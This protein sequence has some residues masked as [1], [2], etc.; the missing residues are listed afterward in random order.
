V[1]AGTDP[2]KNWILRGM[3]RIERGASPKFKQALFSAGY[4]PKGES[5]DQRTRAYSQY[6]GLFKVWVCARSRRRE[7]LTIPLDHIPF[8]RCLIARV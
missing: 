5:I 1:S 4:Y 6:I 7:R 3:P 8:T 2:A